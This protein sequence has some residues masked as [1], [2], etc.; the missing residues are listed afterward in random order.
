MH[1]LSLSLL[2][3]VSFLVVYL[4]VWEKEKFEPEDLMLAEVE[5]SSK[6]AGKEIDYWFAQ[7]KADKNLIKRLF[8][9]ARRTLYGKDA[10][11]NS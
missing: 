3:A 2:Q 6:K 1:G 7:S 11:A 10:R 8:R 5:A 9:K 4:K